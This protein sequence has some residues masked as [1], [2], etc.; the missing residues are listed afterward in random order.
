MRWTAIIS[1]L[2]AGGA[3]L[4]FTAHSFLNSMLALAA[5]FGVSQFVFVQWVAPILSEFPEKVTAFCWARKISAAPMALMNMVSSNINQWTVLAAMIP[6]V[7]SPSVGHMAAFP[8]T[9]RSGMQSGGLC[10]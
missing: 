6:M 8:S 3:L 5:T 2:S 4:H 10:W 1:L 7:Y 9:A